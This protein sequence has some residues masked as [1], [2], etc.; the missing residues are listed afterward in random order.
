[1]LEHLLKAQ[2]YRDQADSFKLLASQEQNQEA[3]KALLATAE[4]YE[5]LH[6]KFLSLAKSGPLVE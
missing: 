1:M 2:H 4:T 3:K 6:L 5:R